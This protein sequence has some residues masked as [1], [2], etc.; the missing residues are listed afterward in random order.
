MIIANATPPQY[1]PRWGLALAILAA[2]ALFAVLPR[3]VQIMP[4]W[5]SH[6]VA[7]AV[8]VPIAAITFPVADIH[9]WLRAERAV[10][11][12]FAG[13][14]VVNTSQDIRIALSEHDHHG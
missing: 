1:E 13:A 11:V 12:L 7:L 6:V 3:H 10:I 14:Y 9:F 2:L 5:V 8:L 4:V